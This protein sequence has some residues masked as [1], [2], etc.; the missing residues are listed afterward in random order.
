MLGTAVAPDA[1]ASSAPLARDFGATAA[2]RAAAA[3]TSVLA[4][5][6]RVNVPALSQIHL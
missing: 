2:T 3:R 1:A 6:K 5:A 4:R